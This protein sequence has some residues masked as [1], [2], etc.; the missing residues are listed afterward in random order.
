MKLAI[1]EWMVGWCFSSSSSPFLEL[2]SSLNQC[3]T[4]I[5]CIDETVLWS[6]IGETIYRY[7]F[8]LCCEY[9]YFMSLF[10]CCFNVSFNW[11]FIVV[12][13]EFPQSFFL[14]LHF[15]VV[16]IVA[17]FPLHTRIFDMMWEINKKKCTMFSMWTKWK[18]NKQTNKWTKKERWREGE[19][20][21]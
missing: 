7:V 16:F 21:P 10:N 19:G 8:V 15:R 12:V 6:D 20:E 14:R 4:A 3:R 2:G 5:K 11:N 17:I 13:V 9:R 18:L 1:G